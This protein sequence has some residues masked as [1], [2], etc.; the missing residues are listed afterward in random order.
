MGFIC[1]RESEVLWMFIAE[2]I[3]GWRILFIEIGN[4]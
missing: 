4:R 1:N 2:V 3:R